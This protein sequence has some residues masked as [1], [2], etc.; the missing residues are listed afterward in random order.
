M[1]FQI[2][3]SIVTLVVGRVEQ[4]WERHLGKGTV[5]LIGFKASSSYGPSIVSEFSR[6]WFRLSKLATYSKTL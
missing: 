4:L 5:T 2:P 6:E 3:Y 1:G